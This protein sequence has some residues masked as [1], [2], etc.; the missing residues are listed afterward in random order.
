[1]QLSTFLST[2]CNNFFKK[3]LFLIALTFSSLLFS[4]KAGTNLFDNTFLHQINLEASGLETI[5]PWSPGIYNAPV[6]MTIDG[7]VV[8][9]VYIRRKGY[10]SNLYNNTNP[11]FKIDID[12]FISNRK[13]DGIDKFNLLNQFSNPNHYQNNAL[14]YALYRRAGV[15]APHTSF[16]EVYINGKFIDIYTITEDI[17]KTFL[18]QNFASND[19]SLYK[20]VEYPPNGAVVQSG[21]IDA[22]NNYINNVNAMNWGT[23]ADLHNLFRVITVDNMIFDDPSGQNNI[24]Y[25]EPK[26]EKMYAIPWDKNQSFGSLPS[27]QILNPIV[28]FLS[29]QSFSL[30]N[31][32]LIKPLYLQTVCNLTSY[33]LDSAFVR[34][35]VMRN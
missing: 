29:G 20:G 4:Q 6:K 5:L 33:L 34:K 23:Y 25:Y 31:D 28:P 24:M 22:F 16:A 14:A 27:A 13:Y 3:V 2:Q 17:E 8:D 32:P 11:P 26:S 21:T 19:G 9:S 18:K 30:I 12:S 10:T 7:V 35:E 15:A 1:M